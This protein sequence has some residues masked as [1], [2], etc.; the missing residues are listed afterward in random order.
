MIEPESSRVNEEFDIVG[1]R[2]DALMESLRA[3]G[4]SL[5]D[6]IADLV[7]NSL[8]ASARNVWMTFH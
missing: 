3:T 7:D 6:A 2:A 4:Y 8:T 1:P 5:P